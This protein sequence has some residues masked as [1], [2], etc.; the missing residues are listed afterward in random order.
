MPIFTYRAKDTQGQTRTGTSEAESAARLAETLRG[1]G[2]AV[3]EIRKARGREARAGGLPPRWHPSW[4]LPVRSLDVELGLR[5][6]AS[7]L[8]SGVSVLA[9]LKTASLQSEKPRAASVWADLDDRIRKGGTLSD[10]MDRHR[11]FFGEYVTQLIRVGEHSGEMD[12]SMTRAAEHLELHR[13]VRMMVINALIYPI[14]AT[15]MAIGVSVYLV[16]VVIPKVA[17]FLEGGGVALPAIT[18]MLM[19]VSFWIRLN[20]LQ[21]LAVAAGVVAAWWAVRCLPA[22]RDR[23]DA[24]LLKLPVAGRVLRLSGTAVFARGMGLLLDSGVTLLDA[25]NVV[26]HLIGNRRLAGRVGA[27]RLS[28]MRGDPLASALDRAPEFL[29]MLARMTAVAETTGT[30]G[31]TLN[32]VARFHENLL[33]ITIK[34]LSVSIEPL[35]IVVTGGIVGFVYIAFFVALFAMASSV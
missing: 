27:A 19:D 31:P 3:L 20:G 22:G 9:A 23:Q 30:L 17:T 15:L 25:L 8:R 34:R 11:R 5:Q 16:V 14:L 1:S 7:M 29:P 2:M 13:N 21:I 10:A 33:V 12:L 28:V 18:Q 24:L 35:M 26:E 6:L 32:E 4:L